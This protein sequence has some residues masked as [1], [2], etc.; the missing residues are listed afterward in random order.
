VESAQ[1]SGVKYTIDVG[2]GDSGV[3]VSLRR[4]L[5]DGGYGDVLG[6]LLSWTPSLVRVERR[7]GTVVEVAPADVVAAKRVPPAPERRR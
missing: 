6:M 5:P 1:P 4:R 7:D 2:V 3:R